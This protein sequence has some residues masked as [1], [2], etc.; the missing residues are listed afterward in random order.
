MNKEAAK[1]PLFRISEKIWGSVELSTI[2]DTTKAM[3]E[4]GVFYPPFKQYSIETSATFGSAE[5][6]RKELELN[7][8]I[9]FLTDKKW[10]CEIV[11][12]DLSTDE[13]PEYYFFL[14]LID[15]NGKVIVN[16]NKHLD[17]EIVCEYA[18]HLVQ[19]LQCSLL[20]LLATKN[21]DKTTVTNKIG[22]AQS[23]EKK[24][25]KKYSTT[26]TIK[27]G[28][29]TESV[30]GHGKVGGKKRPHLRRGH[31]RN[32]RFG[33]ALSEIKK[34]FIEPCFV[35]ADDGWIDTMKDYRVVV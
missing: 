1:Y 25:A 12:D 28:A 31:L 26:T 6:A 24:D 13:E 9:L 23:R 7:S 29:V 27:I 18:H 2:I 22:S 16:L 30:G 8:D 11:F 34:V 20:V 5:W 33:E 35:N 21:A 10:N 3:K 32:Q 15:K 17:N 4:A 19:F 14:N